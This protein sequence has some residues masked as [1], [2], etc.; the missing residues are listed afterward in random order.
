MTEKKLIT[1]FTIDVKEARKNER[2]KQLAFEMHL[3]KLAHRRYLENKL[4]Q[5]YAGVL[6][7]EVKK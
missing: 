5:D 2:I 7:K 4:L 1:D 3:S 6:T